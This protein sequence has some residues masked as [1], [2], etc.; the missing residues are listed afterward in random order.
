[1]ILKAKERGNAPQL[2]RYLLAMRD[3]EHVEL[4]DVRGFISD[5]LI[6]AF[7]EADAIARGTRCEKHMFSMS[8]NPPEGANVSIEDFEKAIEQ[9]EAK[10]GLEGQPRAIVFHEKD[11][12]TPE[13][14]GLRKEAFIAFTAA[15]RGSQEQRE[16]LVTMRTIEDELATRAPGL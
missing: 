15:P 9:V 1:M 4:H 8:F 7:G 16:A 11:G 12:S 10:L 14:Y 2:A 3:N 6:E 5:D 13:L